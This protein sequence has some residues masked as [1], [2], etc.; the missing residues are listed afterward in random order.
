MES[1]ELSI[2]SINA[3]CILV[4]L[5]KILVYSSSISIIFSVNSVILVFIFAIIL[6]ILFVSIEFNDISLNEFSIL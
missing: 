6:L 4:I 2:L 5:V 1:I 3:T